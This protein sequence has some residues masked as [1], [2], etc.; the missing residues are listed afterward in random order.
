[1]AAAKP[2]LTAALLLLATA[3]TA[4]ADNPT[5]RIVKADQQRADKALLR[6]SDIGTIWQ[7]GAVPPTKL[8]A[9]SC[10]GFNPK[11]SDLIVTGHADARFTNTGA[12]ATLSQDVQVL[13][14]EEAVRTDFDRTITPALG[15]C[16]AYQL[17]KAPNVV[18]VSVSRLSFPKLGTVTAAYRATL[19]VKNGSRTV[20]LVDDY[21]FLGVGRYEFALN[22]L[23]PFVVG[24]QLVNFE[25]AMARILIKRVGLCC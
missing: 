16:L 20:K 5:V 23:A 25:A 12:S 6:R 14:N 18:S 2:F 7:G 8:S 21:V 9:P 22:I 17:R 19:V 4:L 10:P 24:D 15:R 13:K 11:E 1:V 3:A